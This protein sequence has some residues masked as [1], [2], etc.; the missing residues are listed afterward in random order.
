MG[1]HFPLKTILQFLEIFLTNN[2][3]IIH[4]IQ[5]LGDR[6]YIFVKMQD[7]C[8]VKVRNR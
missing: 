3:G 7:G 6:E 1:P 5:Y 8:T 4:R 2:N